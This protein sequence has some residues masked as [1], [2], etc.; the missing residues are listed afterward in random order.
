[1]QAQRF[2][3][4]VA[5]R[6]LPARRQFAA[7][8]ATRVAPPAWS[9][10]AAAAAAASAAAA[11]VALNTLRLPPVCADEGDAAFAEVQ[12]QAA[13]AEVSE[14]EAVSSAFVFIKPHAVTEQTRRLV[15][16]RFAAEGIEV[17]SE[18]SIPAERVDKEML[19]DTH[20]GA[21]AARA[22]RQHPSELAVQPAAKEAFQKA[23]GLSWESALKDGCVYNLVDGSAKLGISM[24]ELG[25][26]YDKLKKGVDMLK[27]GGGFYCGKVDGIYVI[28]GFYASMRSRFTIPNTC[29]HYYE[30]RWSPSQLS[31]GDFRG[32][33]LGGTD[34]KTAEPG[35]LRNEIF[36]TWRELGLTSEPTTGDNG[37]HASASPFEAMSE[38]SNWLG[39]PLETDFYGRAMLA[40][41]IPASV[42]RH[43]C[44]DPAVRYE[45]KKQ[46]LF[47]LLEDLDGKECLKK[48]ASIHA[49]A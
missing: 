22:M 24:A 12:R 14:A 16:E 28:N 4:V 47:D 32:K 27:F 13:A 41:G 10:A 45:G 1:M 43:W 20:Y 49:A 9:A 36:S 8:A 42:I 23:F 15:T 21:I 30:V 39:V 11:A 17:V 48:S 46:S 26:K 40:L 18:G 35:S 29:I 2:A 19:I 6:V 44:D 34:P 38:R 5:R 33:V 25:A 7:S 37:V 31:W 3:S